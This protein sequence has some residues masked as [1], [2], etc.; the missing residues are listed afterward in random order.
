MSLYSLNGAYPTPLPNKILLSDGTTKTDSTTFTEAD[1]A[2]AGYV[3]VSDPPAVTYPNILTWDGSNWGN[4]PPNT[5]E[6]LIKIQRL[7]D[8]AEQRLRES[9]FRVIKA[10]ENNTTL[11]TAW[12]T[13][14]QDLRDFYNNISYEVDPWTATFPTLSIDVVDEV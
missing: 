4:R 5:N 13:Y 12:M 11:D 10:Y 3:E 1:L 9:D 8:L 7:K 2:D 6:T 14:R